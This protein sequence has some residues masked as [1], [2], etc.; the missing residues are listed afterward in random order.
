[1]SCGKLGRTK[2]GLIVLAGL[3]HGVAAKLKVPIITG[4][5]CC[6]VIARNCCKNAST[7]YYS[8]NPKNA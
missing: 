2:L 8:G 5:N 4:F 3:K 6:V 1:M 7:D